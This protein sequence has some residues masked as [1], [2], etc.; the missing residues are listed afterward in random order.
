MVASR[1]AE[2]ALASAAAPDDSSSFSFARA[3][4]RAYVSSL[5]AP[6]SSRADRFRCCSANTSDA[7]ACCCVTASPSRCISLSRA[8]APASAVISLCNSSA[9]IVPLLKASFSSDARL[10]RATIAEEA[11]D[12]LE[13]K[14]PKSISDTWSASRATCAA[15]FPNDAREAAAWLAPETTPLADMLARIASARV[16]AIRHRDSL[17]SSAAICSADIGGFSIGMKSSSRGGLLRPQYGASTAA[18]IRAACL[19]SPPIG[20]TYRCNAS[21]RRYSATS[22]RSPSSRSVMPR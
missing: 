8:A 16:V 12:A 3:M 11:L 19:H 5:M 13:A 18:T 10:A 20:F 17:L 1:A 22:I 4:A 14:E 6:A 7:E 2:A 9:E 21:H 15:V